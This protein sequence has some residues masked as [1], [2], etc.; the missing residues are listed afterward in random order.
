MKIELL[1]FDGCPNHEQALENLQE[2]LQQLLLDQQVERIKV[3][4]NEDAVKHRFL[5][6][7]S[8]RINGKD[9]EIEEDDTTEY[10]MQ[11]RRYQTKSG[12]QGYP[13]KELILT[14]LKG[15]TDSNKS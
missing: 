5:G 12:I 11:C 6:S 1:Y 10:S 14:A 15:V 13:P 9:L 3:E 2:C 8:I 4:N 7:P